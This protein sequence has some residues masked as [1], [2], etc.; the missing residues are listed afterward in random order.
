MVDES[1]PTGTCGCCIMSKER[2]LVANLAA[3]NNYKVVMQ[4]SNHCLPYN[5]LC[6]GHCNIDTGRENLVKLFS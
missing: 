4:Q 3:A 6:Q 5:R 2:T 1:T